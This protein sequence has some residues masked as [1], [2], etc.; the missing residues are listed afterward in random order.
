[1]HPGPSTIFK[2]IVLSGLGKEAQISKARG[3]RF[4]GFGDV[5]GLGLRVAVAGRKSWA[6][7]LVAL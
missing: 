7:A 2:D 4:W 1:M 6:V 3:S 5:S